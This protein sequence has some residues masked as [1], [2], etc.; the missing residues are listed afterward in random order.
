MSIF[1]I[2]VTLPNKNMP[3]LKPTI[4]HKIESDTLGHSVYV[5]ETRLLKQVQLNDPNCTTI[6]T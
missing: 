6:T 4:L 1:L 3:C 5:S 2:C